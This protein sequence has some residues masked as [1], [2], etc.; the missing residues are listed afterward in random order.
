MFTDWIV[1]RHFHPN[2]INV[3]M[4]EIG[5]GKLNNL[6]KFP[7]LY[8]VEGT[9]EGRSSKGLQL[10][11]GDLSAVELRPNKAPLLQL[12]QQ[13]FF[14]ENA[15]V[16]KSALL[17][18]YFV[19]AVTIQN[20]KLAAP[21]LNTSDQELE[22]ISGLR[23]ATVRDIQRRIGDGTYIEEF[24]IVKS[25]FVN[26]RE[27]G[28]S[29]GV[30]DYEA[31]DNSFVCKNLSLNSLRS[32]LRLQMG[33]RAIELIYNSEEH[34]FRSKPELCKKLEAEFNS[35]W[36]NVTQQGAR[37]IRR[38]MEVIQTGLMFFRGF[39]SMASVFGQMM[40]SQGQVG[41]LLG[42]QL[43]LRFFSVTQFILYLTRSAATSFIFASSPAL[44][45]S[46]PFLLAFALLRS[47]SL[48]SVFGFGTLVSAGATQHSAYP[49]RMLQQYY[50]VAD[51]F[52]ILSSSETDQLKQGMDLVRDSQ[53]QFDT[54]VDR[55][56]AEAQANPSSW[57]PSLLPSDFRTVCASLTRN[58]DTAST[59]DLLY[60]LSLDQSVTTK[61]IDY[62]NSRLFDA[63]AKLSRSFASSITIDDVLDSRGRL[64]SPAHV[65]AA[66]YLRR[67][68][69]KLTSLDKL[70]D[71]FLPYAAE[72]PQA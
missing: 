52:P 59:A 26:V 17:L 39:L 63:A 21:V 8:Y 71:R 18:A 65:C 29:V 32:I 22:Q 38:I 20:K 14:S 57:N 41:R 67:G 37:I 68:F 13:A 3:S 40:T 43:F 6:N 46:I 31:L 16:Q 25:F 50:T 60:Q 53:Q 34:R 49:P 4:Q 19:R 12:F 5:Q 15:L 61:F 55:I 45:I 72:Q 47:N 27:T 54:E 33:N 23:D 56:V 51:R 28:E 35:A 30:S 44:L 66:V 62:L 2:I 69:A 1:S 7:V 48:S 11:L 36:S 42:I 58:N 24:E 70:M 10:L 9:T 64:R